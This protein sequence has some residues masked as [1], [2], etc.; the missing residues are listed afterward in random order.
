MMESYSIPSCRLSTGV[1]AAERIPDDGCADT[2]GPLNGIQEVDD[3]DLKAT[4]TSSG[5]NEDLS[6]GLFPPCQLVD[7]V[8]QGVSP[9][10]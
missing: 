2:S 3:A 8:V 6:K 7:E 9:F 4:G 1:V 5:A 10:R